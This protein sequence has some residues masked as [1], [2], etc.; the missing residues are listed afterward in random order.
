MHT[1]LL[2]KL[3]FLM[4]S[5]HADSV[6]TSTCSSLLYM[7]TQ[8]AVFTLENVT[9]WVQIC[10]Q[11]ALFTQHTQNVPFTCIHATCPVLHIN[12]AACPIYTCT[13]Y[14]PNFS[15]STQKTHLHHKDPFTHKHTAAP[16][17]HIYKFTH[18]PAAGPVYTCTCSMSLFTH[19]QAT[20]S[21]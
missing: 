16:C 14:R 10:T 11:Q 7:Q 21:I 17:L 18:V 9:G 19:V 3:R 20:C 4:Y 12:I 6:Y 5:L 1:Q 15:V 8:Q 13:L 2:S